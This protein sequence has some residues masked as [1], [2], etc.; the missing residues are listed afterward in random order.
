MAR[1]DPRHCSSDRR[2]RDEPDPSGTPQEFTRRAVAPD[3]GFEMMLAVAIASLGL[4]VWATP[5]LVYGVSAWLRHLPAGE[6]SHRRAILFG[7]AVAQLPVVFLWI[8]FGVVT[9]SRIPVDSSRLFG[10]LVLILGTA[11]LVLPCRNRTVLVLAGVGSISASASA[12]RPSST[13]RSKPLKKSTLDCVFSTSAHQKPLRTA[14]GT[15]R[16]CVIQAKTT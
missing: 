11:H 4:V 9:L 6:A 3:G 8:F 7:L 16:I 14:I 2:G 13:S 10:V 12:V 1:R 5:R 15:V